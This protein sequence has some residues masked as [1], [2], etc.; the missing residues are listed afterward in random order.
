MHAA[1]STKIIS[2]PSTSPLT[3]HHDHLL[4]PVGEYFRILYHVVLYVLYVVYAY[5]YLKVYVSKILKKHILP[6][7]LLSKCSS[8]FHSTCS[9]MSHVVLVY[10]SNRR[11]FNTD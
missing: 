3:P 1:T 7:E 9:M 2:I 6:S 11:V 5:L 10:F 4:L 8:P